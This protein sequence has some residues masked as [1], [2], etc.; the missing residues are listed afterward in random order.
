MSQDR[1][2]TCAECGV[3]FVWTAAG[4]AGETLPALCPGCRLLA[5]PAGRQ[6]GIVKW[7]NHGK[8]YGFI[9]PKSGGDLFVH[10]SGLTSGQPLPR[11]DQLVEFS[12][13]TTPRGMQAEEVSLLEVGEQP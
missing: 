2:L 5:P 10:R 6:R 11:A 4:Q 1:L 13:V 7:F 12:V 9:T 3:T 8:G